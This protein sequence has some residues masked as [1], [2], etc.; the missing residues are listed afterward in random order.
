MTFPLQYF[1]PHDNEFLNFQIS[2]GCFV[3]KV[4]LQIETQDTRIAWKTG[5]NTRHEPHKRQK[6]PRLH[7]S[8]GKQKEAA[9][10]TLFTKVATLKNVKKYKV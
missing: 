10:T 3:K 1:A 4:W 8:R 9:V 5:K 2:E 7:E 6:K